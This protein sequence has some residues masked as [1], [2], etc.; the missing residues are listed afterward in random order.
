M[1]RKSDFFWL[2]LITVTIGCYLYFAT[3]ANMDLT[4]G[5]FALF[6][7]EKVTFDG[8]Q[9]ILYPENFQ[10][11]L[12]NIYN[13][14]DHRYGR[15]LWNSIALFSYIPASI[16]EVPGQIISARMLQVLLLISSYLILGMA[17]LKSW[18][19]RFFLLLLLLA[20][21]FT[22]YY[23]TMPK[24][25]PLQLLFLSLFLYYFIR[26][27]MEFREK[28]WLLLGLA[29]GTKISILPMI[30][31]LTAWAIWVEFKKFTRS[32]LFDKLVKAVGYFLAGLAL[33]VP[34]LS[35]TFI[36][37]SL[38]YIITIFIVTRLFKVSSVRL[39]WIKA[40]VLVGIFA[41]TIILAYLNYTKGGKSGIASW[42]GAV[43]MNTKNAADLPSVNFITWI[44]YVST[45][46]IIAPLWLTC[47]LAL[48]CLVFFYS[49]SG[50]IWNAI[51]QRLDMNF[52]F[53]SVITLAGLILCASIMMTVHRL[54]GFYLFIGTI[55]FIS[56]LISL[57]EQRLSMK[58]SELSSN[59][60]KTSVY[61]LWALILALC[62]LIYF[63]VP[64]SLNSY[65]S[66][67]KRTQTSSYKKN[68]ASYVLIDSL[69]NEY[70]KNRQKKLS[71]SIDPEL[72]APVSNSKYT[73]D[74]F[75]GPFILWDSKYDIVILGASHLP[76]KQPMKTESALY[77]DFL[78]ER[79]SYNSFVVER[80][81]SCRQEFCYERIL[82]LPNGG[83]VLVLKHFTGS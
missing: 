8:V 9:K 6:M 27:G 56:G 38:V 45:N 69:L 74:E 83:E 59:T 60:H 52:L 34:I 46:W 41:A 2:V 43:I 63:W 10:S 14:L 31:L 13:G 49:I 53:A 30:G 23:S 18:R 66:L 7:D 55:L 21:P 24:P 72:F 12:F 64:A 50:K 25:E 15:S 5:R 47:F 68:Y 42:G 80:N 29:F 20:L 58:I 76:G 11:F 19:A 1:K 78:K 57:S 73:L 71:V 35:P 81:E 40:I 39:I 17:L 22:D 33:A 3:I 62:M 48:S 16:Y 70:S 75:W 82:T 77:K 4:D 51:L 67:A 54:W 37:S 28:Y 26:S 44:K 79:D 36:I 61:P 65:L 32:V